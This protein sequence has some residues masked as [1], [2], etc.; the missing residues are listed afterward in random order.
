[1]KNNNHLY[2]FI[3]A[4]TFFI[5]ISINCHADKFLFQIMDITGSDTV[6][7]IDGIKMHRYDVFTENQKWQWDGDAD[8]TVY[9]TPLDSE[10]G[11]TIKITKGEMKEKKAS[12]LAYLNLSGKGINKRNDVFVLYSNKKEIKLP[13]KYEQNVTY[14]IQLDDAMIPLKIRDKGIYVTYDMFK[15]KKTVLTSWIFKREYESADDYSDV[16]I[17]QYTFYI[18]K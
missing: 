8:I 18:N 4:L 1:M 5:C 14:F 10:I 17:A 6:I 11:G 9:V 12:T 3:S 2:R 15:Q 16:P 13:I 7:V